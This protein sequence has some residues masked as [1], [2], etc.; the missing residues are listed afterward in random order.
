MFLCGETG[1]SVSDLREEAI[2]MK[3]FDHV[4]YSLLTTVFQ[5]I[6]NNYCHI[7]VVNCLVI[8]YCGTEIL[9]LFLV[10]SQIAL[11]TYVKILRFFCLMFLLCLLYLYNSRT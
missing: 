9:A 5:R 6:L 8:Y 2:L 1:L 11:S 10:L 4:S 3:Q 7:Y